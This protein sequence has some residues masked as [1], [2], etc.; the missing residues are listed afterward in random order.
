MLNQDTRRYSRK[1]IEALA[2][3]DPVVAS[4]MSHLNSGVEWSY[5]EA[6][7]CMVCMLVEEKKTILASALMALQLKPKQEIIDGRDRILP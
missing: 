5:E 2:R 3:T 7:I 4:V 6:L 1:D